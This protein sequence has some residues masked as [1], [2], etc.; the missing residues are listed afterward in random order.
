MRA[1]QPEEVAMRRRAA[2]T[3]TWSSEMQEMGEV[4]LM[5]RVVR[6]QG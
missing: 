3:A 5:M 2:G 6:V 4:A 1:H